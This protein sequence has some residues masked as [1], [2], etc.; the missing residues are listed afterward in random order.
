MAVPVKPSSGQTF[1]WGQAVRLFNAQPYM[2]GPTAGY[3][4]GLD[5]TRFLMIV[6]DTAQLSTR[7]TTIEYVTNWFEELRAR[8]K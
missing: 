4:V 5:G 6:D 2:R 8:V 3:D 7:R 1:D